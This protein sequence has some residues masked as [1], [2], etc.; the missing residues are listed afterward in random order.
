M[1]NVL[2]PRDGIWFRSLKDK[3]CKD[4]GIKYPWYVLDF[5]HRNPIDK[6]FSLSTGC[7]RHSREDVLKEIEKCDLICANCHRIREYKYKDTA[8]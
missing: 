7:Y 8:I 4:C 5:H 3:P 1:L 2:F 6:S